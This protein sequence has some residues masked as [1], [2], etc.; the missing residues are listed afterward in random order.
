MKCPKC[1]EPGSTVVDSRNA[2]AARR[3]RRE[4]KKCG[5]RFTTTEVYG[6]Q[7]QDEM[8][9]FLPD[10]RGRDGAA[11]TFDRA[12]LAAS[13][14]D[15]CRDRPVAREDV[16][17]FIA[18]HVA[19]LSEAPDKV[20][21]VAALVDQTIAGLVKIDKL[22]AMRYAVRHMQFSTST[23]FLRFLNKIGK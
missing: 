16:D 19:H 11:E 12:R 8:P 2:D 20:M 23:K 18:D 1:G 6:I 14:D 13:V 9:L 22:A 7:K 10:V 21:D 17:E 5:E 15:A 4:C 3:R